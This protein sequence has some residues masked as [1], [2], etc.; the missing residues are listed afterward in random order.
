MCRATFLGTL[1][2]GQRTSNTIA[3]VNPG[4]GTAPTYADLQEL[5]TELLTQFATTYKAIGTTTW[6]WDSILTKNVVV[7]GTTDTYQEAATTV[8]APGTR[9]DTTTWIPDSVCGVLS[10]KTANAS[11][12]FRGHLFMQPART[13]SS[14]GGNLLATGDG[15]HTALTNFATE[16]AKG[17]IGGVGWTG[18]TLASFKL[19]VFSRAAAIAGAPYVA[20]C[21]AVTVRPDARWLRSREHGGS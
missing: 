19:H 4:A 11:R 9:S 14:V 18:G 2:N 10:L 5:G 16:L 7:P 12:R 15:Y 21:T 1:A 17:C 3:I 13:Q 6:T 20:E 8:A